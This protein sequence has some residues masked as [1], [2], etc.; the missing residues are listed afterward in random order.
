MRGRSATTR[1]KARRASQPNAGARHHCLTEQ[2]AQRRREGVASAASDVAQRPSTRMCELVPA[3]IRRE[4]QGTGEAGAEP[5]RARRKAFW[6]L[7]RREKGL[8]GRRPVK[9]SLCRRPSP[10]SRCVCILRCDAQ[11]PIITVLLLRGGAVWQLVGL[12]TRRSQVQILPPLP[13]LVDKKAS[14]RGFFVGWLQGRR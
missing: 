6:V 3:R 2:A 5:A 8:A 4:A 9:A 7:F 10:E 12:I 13:V 11:P 1:R 14:S